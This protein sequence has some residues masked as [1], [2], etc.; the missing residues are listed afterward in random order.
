MFTDRPHRRAEIGGGAHLSK[1]D[2]LPAL[3]KGRSSF[4]GDA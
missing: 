2:R 1:H 3:H 4:W